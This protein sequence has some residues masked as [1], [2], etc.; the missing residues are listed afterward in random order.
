MSFSTSLTKSIAAEEALQLLAIPGI[1]G[2]WGIWTSWGTKKGG[3]CLKLITGPL[4][5]FLTLHTKSLFLGPLGCLR[6]FESRLNPQDPRSTDI[7]HDAQLLSTVAYCSTAFSFIS[8]KPSSG[9]MHSSACWATHLSHR[10]TFLR[11]NHLPPWSPWCVFGTAFFLIHVC[12]S[13]TTE[14]PVPT[15]ANQP[16]SFLN[17]NQ[18][19]KYFRKTLNKIKKHQE[20]GFQMSM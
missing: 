18:V 20:A 4:G 12:V 14:F 5:L 6:S 2:I 16:S 1:L 17:S 7:F 3:N 13:Y 11:G 15:A 9:N 10:T 19:M 8:T